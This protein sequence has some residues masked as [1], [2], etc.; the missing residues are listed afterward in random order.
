MRP[1]L[2]VRGI[3]VYYRWRKYE[4]GRFV[5]GPSVRVNP[6]GRLVHEDRQLMTIPIDAWVRLEVAAGLGEGLGQTFEL[7]VTLPDGKSRVFSDLPS[8]PGFDR[9]DWFASQVRTF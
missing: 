4:G 7:R 9:L 1:H 3:H 6:S 8:E 2:P 5:R